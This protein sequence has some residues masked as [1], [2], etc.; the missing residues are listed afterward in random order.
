MKITKSQLKQ[1]IKEELESV[2]NEGWLDRMNPFKK[3][4]WPPRA[5]EKSHMLLDPSSG[6]KHS[7]TT[8][9]D[10]RLNQQSFDT[11]GD[12]D[13]DKLDPEA[14]RRAL[15]AAAPGGVDKAS[16]KEA[17]ALL[18]KLGGHEDPYGESSPICTSGK[19]SSYGGG[20]TSKDID[21]RYVPMIE[22]LRT[23]V[24]EKPA[25]KHWDYLFAAFEKD[26]YNQIDDE[27][28]VSALLDIKNGKVN[29]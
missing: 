16:K 19:H 27:D 17:E 10:P 5:P 8:K 9:D 29:I 15:Y 21:E 23:K 20:C 13:V 22:F 4:P 1:I 6:G 12:G 7:W 2:L 28:L 26:V 14:V 25:G 24:K 3:E 11:D 18:V